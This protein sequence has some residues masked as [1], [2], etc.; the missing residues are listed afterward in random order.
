MNVSTFFWSARR[1]SALVGLLACILATKLGCEGEEKPAKRT[2]FCS[3]PKKRPDFLIK[4]P[5]YGGIP[6]AVSP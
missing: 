4:D 5:H 3:F 6:Y 2:V 1:R